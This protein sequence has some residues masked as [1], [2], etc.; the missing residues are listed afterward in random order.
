MI[1]VALG[2]AVAILLTGARSF[3][4]A[5]E[6]GLAQDKQESERLVW[7]ASKITGS[8]EPPP[9][10]RAERAFAALTFKKP[11]QLV[12]FP[13]YRRYAL[14]EEDGAIYSFRNDPACEKADPFLDVR[15]E[16]LNLDKVEKCRGAE[17]TYSIAFDPDFAKNRF[18]Y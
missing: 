8:P 11:V 15:K 2:I 1:R 13:G 14:V 16:I 4:S 3:D 18:C 7:T 5:G 10:L 9:P 17:Y 6:A 12:A